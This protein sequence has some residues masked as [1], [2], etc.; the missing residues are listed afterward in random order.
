MIC[1]RTFSSRST[2]DR[3]CFAERHLVG[4]LKNISERLGAFA[5]KPAHR[6]AELV[7]R[8]DDRIDLLAQNQPRQMEHRAD[9]D[10]RAEIRRA[11]RQIAKLVVEG[12]IQLLLQLGIQMVNRAPRLPQ[13]QPGP[14]RLHPQMVLLVDHHTETFLAVQHQAAAGAFRRVFAADEMA[15][16]QNLLVERAEIVHRLRKRALHLRQAL[17]RRTDHLQN[18]HAL[19]LFRP[20]GKRRAAQIA[21]QPHAARHDDAIMRAVALRGLGGRNQKFVKIHLFWQ[22]RRRLDARSIV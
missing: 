5:V 17:D 22:M 15:L 13:L 21:R 19:R 12:I 20:A 7:D 6:E 18:F 14:Q 8:L 1:A 9:A 16:D 4:N 10:A 2:I 3:L 11:G